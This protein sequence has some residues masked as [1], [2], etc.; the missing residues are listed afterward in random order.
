MY[1]KFMV[2]SHDIIGDCSYLELN[3]LV[4]DPWIETRSSRY[5]S[6]S[7]A[8]GAN[9][10]ADYCVEEMYANNQHNK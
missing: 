5:C 10:V 6:M 7:S 8:L 1:L 2:A 9:G 4:C 3:C